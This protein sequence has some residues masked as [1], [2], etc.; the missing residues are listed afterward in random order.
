M[1][2]LF[3][4]WLVV[5]ALGIA[6]LPLTTTLFAHLPDRGWALSKPLGILAA[7]WLIWFPLA[8]FNALPYSRAWIAGVLVVFIAG[9]A[10]LLRDRERRETLR[11]ILVGGR[12]YVLACELLFTA[13]YLFMA[14]LRSFTPAVVDT[15]KFMDVAFISSL[16]RTPHLPAPDPWLSGAPINYYYFGHFLIATLAKLLG[17]QPG[18]AFNVGIAL[19]F[20]LAAA[21]VFGVAASMFASRFAGGA[22]LWRAIPAGLASVLLVFVLG[23]LNGAQI[24]WQNAQAAAHT[25]PALN[26]NP[27]LWWLHRELWTTYDWW[28]PSRVIPNTINEF[29][30]FSFVLADLHAHVLALPFCALAVGIAFNLLLASGEGI[31]AFGRGFSGALG[32]ATA[33]VLIGA[34]YAINGWD[35]PTYLGLALLA[36]A[37]QQ[38]L[39][40]GRR[41]GS[42]LVLDFGAVAAMLTALCFL[43]YLP[44]YRGFVS[45]SQ[46]VAIVGAA[47]RSPIG[48]EL[49]IF[50][51]PLFIAVSLIVVRLIRDLAGVLAT[52]PRMPAT[53]SGAADMRSWGLTAR[54]PILV[55]AEAVG[56][57]LAALALWTWATATSL[58][59]TLFWSSLALLACI[60]LVVRRLL[61][62]ADDSQIAAKTASGSA[63]SLAELWVYVLVG[64]AA[65]LIAV[66]EVVYLRDIFGTRMNTVFKLYFQAWLLL[67]IAAGPALVWLLPA[68]CRIVAAAITD[69]ADSGMRRTAPRPAPSGALALARVRAGDTPD[70]AMRLPLIGTRLFAHAAAPLPAVAGSTAGSGQALD[71]ASQAPEIPA[72]LRWLGAGGMLLWM[73]VLAALVCAALV[74]PTLAASARTENFSL[75][76]GLDGTAYMT[77]DPSPGIVGCQVGGGTNLDDNEAIAW[78]NAN[79][80][81]SPV[82]VEAPGCEWSHYSRVSAF[83]GLPTLLGWPGGHEFEWRVNWLPENTQGDIFAQ[84]Q[85]DVN[86]IYSNP[87]PR[88]VSALLQRY[89][90]RFVYVGAAERALYPSAGLSR[91]AG[92]LRVVY[93]RDGVTIYETQH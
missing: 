71:D 64:T 39:A 46:G 30:A 80:Q 84:R 28:S 6:A 53:Q 23:N 5:E 10:A 16:W 81:G 57:V 14:W 22:R 59:W 60:V 79:V 32:L 31:R 74:Y 76:R 82:I 68:G 41:L 37:I 73:V 78:L 29:P 91:L 17:T 12:A 48:D 45:P 36:L 38:W 7:G 25:A 50:G 20:A 58:G 21:A 3:S 77:S 70:V 44:F 47:D 69:A 89:H 8:L 72:A 51:L 65:A 87:D 62:Y 24:W 66:A 52:G 40:H 43:L 92:F 56:V 88:I 67:G 93:N 49:A 9:N 2:V 26:G 90:V 54:Y 33:A 85:Q 75:S 55:A 27:W 19:I 13:S 4:W 1:G 61:R 11:R 83:T 15:E 63:M 35:L 42:P 18:T 86:T 34:L